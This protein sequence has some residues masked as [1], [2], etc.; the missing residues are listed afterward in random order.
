M[1]RPRTVS[2]WEK[3]PNRRDVRLVRGWD[4]GGRTTSKAQKGA[5]LSHM[6]DSNARSGLGRL[7]VIRLQ[8]QILLATEQTSNIKADWLSQNPCWQDAIYPGLLI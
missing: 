3:L 7:L 2:C 1:S 6:G 4:P 8:N 5:C